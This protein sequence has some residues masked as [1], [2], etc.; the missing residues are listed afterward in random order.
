MNTLAE[1]SY[2]DSI[3]QDLYVYCDICQYSYV[4]DGY[5]PILKIENGSDIYDKLFY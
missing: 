1:L 5:K 3:E 4:T 2:P